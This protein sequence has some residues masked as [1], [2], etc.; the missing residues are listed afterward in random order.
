MKHQH[1]LSLAVLLCLT[2]TTLP[3]QT[4]PERQ[5]DFMV[6][7]EGA[8]TVFAPI[9]PPL[10]QRTGAPPAFYDY[11][12]EFGDGAFSFEENPRHAYAD[13][14]KKEAY[15]MGTGKYDNGKAPRSRKK[16][17]EPPKGKP[18]PK[19]A[20][21]SPAVLPGATAAIGLRAVR[22]PRADEESVFILAYA[23][24][25]PT[26]Q[27]GMIY[28]FY[29]QRDYK[30]EHFSFMEARTHFGEQ[31]ETQPLSWTGPPLRYDAWVDAEAPRHYY[32]LGLNTTQD[33]GAAL[34]ELRKTFKTGL[35]WRFSELQAGE[36]R[37][38]FISLQASGQMLAD[39]NAIITVPALIVSDD[40]RIVE[41]YDLEL[42]IVASHDPNHI[43]VSKR[44][45]GF[46]GIRGKDLIYKV[47]FQNNGEGPAS[48][49]EI[50]C[51]VPPGLDASR[52]QV[53]EAYPLKAPCSEDTGD[54]SCLDTTLKEGQVVFTFRHIYLPG[55]R[56]EGVRDRDSTKGYVK[57][58]IT[59]G[60]DIRK[61]D[62]ASQAS[63][64]FDKNPPIRTN[65]AATSFKPG[66]SP[67]LAAGWNVFPGQSESNHFVLGATLSPFSPYRMFLQAELWAGF[68][69]QPQ[70]SESTARDSLRWMQ[71]I[72]GL[73]FVA[74]IDSITTFTKRT[75]QRPL[76]FRIAPLQL[77]KNI[78]DWI[79]IGAGLM[80][81]V[82]IERTEVRNEVKTQRFVFN[83]EGFPVTDL[84]RE[85]NF[86]HVNTQRETTI[87]PAFFA[88]VQLG[89]VR[90][91]PALGLRG[92][93]NLEQ[94]AEGYVS[95]YA[96]WKF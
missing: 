14:T 86:Q 62:M 51:D 66:F 57:Y 49:V 81:D 89:L 85:S 39:T 84:Y 3:A 77:R 68:P 12:W 6:R 82:R 46:R 74:T 19:L 88:D 56:Q 30:H 78:N 37:H 69:L 53:L 34:G 83:P 90:K 47:Q 7:N 28:L 13:T 17:V 36:L 4:I 22:N 31:Q 79:G 8:F 91:G 18:A 80:L 32:A 93:W 10:A 15:F 29:N 21:A 48:T 76:Y 2:S 38:M 95:A 50:T 70:S 44:R 67:G 40:R 1:P 94:S 41:Q 60:R 63:I 55:T 96:G 42:E 92:V 43:A 71:D 27:S 35:A 5:A 72:Q 59:P 58:R 20:E 11:Y 23:N 33:A 45:T 61:L 9:L 25:T 65:R 64:V 54:G 75:E 73:G 52:M 87:R 16:T 24:S 26:V